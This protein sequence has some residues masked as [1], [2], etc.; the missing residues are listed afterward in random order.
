MICILFIP[1]FLKMLNFSLTLITMLGPIFFFDRWLY[2]PA[3]TGIASKLPGAPW[4]R[5][6][7]I[8]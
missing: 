8:L 6:V 7:A 2:S 5:P 4:L 3:I 1:C